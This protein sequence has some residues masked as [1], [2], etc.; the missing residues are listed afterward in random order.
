[1]ACDNIFNIV[2]GDNHPVITGTWEDTDITGYT[3]TLQILED[4]SDSPTEVAGTLTDAE[5]GEFQFELP[6][7]LG[8]GK[9]PA[10]IQSEDAGDNDETFVGFFVQVHGVWS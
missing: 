6:R 8:P 1:M 4:A 7:T 10:R 9:H 5:A 2:E 3:L